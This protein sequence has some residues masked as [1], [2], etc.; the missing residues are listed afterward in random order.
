MIASGIVPP[1]MEGAGQP[2]ADLL[3]RLV[4]PGQG[5]ELVSQVNGIPK[6]SRLAVSTNLLASLIAVCMRATGNRAH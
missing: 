6:G 2:L 5:I 3:A 1:G 4:G